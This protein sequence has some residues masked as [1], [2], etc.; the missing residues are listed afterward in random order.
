MHVRRVEKN[1]N[2]SGVCFKQE[3]TAELANTRA[4]AHTAAVPLPL[5]S[6]SLV[7]KHTRKIGE[8]PELRQLWMRWCSFSPPSPH[9]T[10][11]PHIGSRP[12]NLTWL[13]E[14]GVRSQHRVESETRSQT[15]ETQ[16][17]ISTEKPVVFVFTKSWLHSPTTRFNKSVG[18]SDSWAYVRNNERPQL[19]I[20]TLHLCN[21]NSK[22]NPHTVF[23]LCL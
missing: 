16:W 5:C 19:L 23:A 9:C 3:Y 21:T 15:Q 20:W 8:L 1:K 7:W 12:G 17:V 14:R 11:S 22:I 18:C 10:R 6:C 2:L 13:W 4:G